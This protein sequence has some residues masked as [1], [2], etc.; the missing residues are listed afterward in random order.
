MRVFGRMT[1]RLCELLQLGNLWGSFSVNC[2][3]VE[4]AFKLRPDVYLPA[5]NSNQQ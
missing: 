3:P 5:T 4:F 2:E 1:G